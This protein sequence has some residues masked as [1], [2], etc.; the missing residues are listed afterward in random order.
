MSV[1]FAT[2]F[3]QVTNAAAG[4][5]PVDPNAAQQQAPGW[6]SF[7]FMLLLV[8]MFY[9]VLIRP[10]MQA[11]KKQEETIKSAKAGDRIVTTGGIHGVITTVKETTVI[12]KIADNTKLELEKSHIER[13]TKTDNSA[14]EKTVAKS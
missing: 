14:P 2:F 8:V 12:V 6:S 4:N 3:A 7:V 9:F 13:I 11:K 5:G 10:Q 1:S